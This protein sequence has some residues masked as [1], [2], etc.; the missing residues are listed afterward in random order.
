MNY[1]RSV[2]RKVRTALSISP[3][4]W[5]ILFKSWVLLLWFD[6]L[7]KSLPFPRVL[8]IASSHSVQEPP[9]QAWAIIRRCQRMVQLTSRM[10]LY[11]MECLRQA[12][13]LKKILGGRGIDTE[14]RFGVRKTSEIFLAH[15]WLEYEG[16]SI[17]LS[18]S[19]IT[20]DQLS[21]LKE[22]S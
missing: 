11:K 5:G 17:E 13:A 2:S 15:A 20:F 7:L 4:D 3:G 22:R 14:L 8:A 1:Y 18:N 10:H 6:L 19:R 16:I 12:L 9:D 21:T